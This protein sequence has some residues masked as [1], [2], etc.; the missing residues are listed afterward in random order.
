MRFFGSKIGIKTNG[1]LELVIAGLLADQKGVLAM[2]AR[3]HMIMV[4]AAER[5][6]R[7]E[8]EIVLHLCSISFHLLIMYALL[9][10]LVSMFRFFISIFFCIT[11]SKIHIIPI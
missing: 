2:L 9:E 4:T 6:D 10:I 7:V 11:E 1:L 3:V 8:M 5:M